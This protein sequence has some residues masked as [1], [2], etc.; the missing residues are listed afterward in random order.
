MTESRQPLRVVT[1]NLQCDHHGG[2]VDAPIDLLAG[3]HA[4]V[5]C[6]QEAKECSPRAV[7]VHLGGRA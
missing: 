1:Y 6:V 5:L 7:H 2:Q 4:D 3:L